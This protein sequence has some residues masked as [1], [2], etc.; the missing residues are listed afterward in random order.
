M[1]LSPNRGSET[2]LMMALLASAFVIAACGDTDSPVT[3]RV[4]IEG[5]LFAREPDRQLRL[6]ERLREISGLAVSPD[7]RVFAHDDETAAIYELDIER[8]GVVKVFALGDPALTGDFE[9][10]AITPAGEFWLM[11]ST[12]ELY[13]FR[14]GADGAH[15]TYER[16]NAGTEELCELEG[17]TYSASAN[18][19]ILA[20]KR[21]HD[22][23]M[24]G[25]PILLSWAPGGAEP[26]SEWRRAQ[27]SFAD[28]T[29]VRRFQ[30]S[31]VDIDSRTGRIIVLSANDAAMVELDADGG[32]LSAR[33]LEGP[34][35]Q[36]EGLVILPDGS[37]LISDE[38]GDGQ[39]LLSRYARLP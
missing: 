21:N 15:A 13:Q 5:S 36:A 25:T 18:S 8:G 23:A 28:A 19:L 17:L 12:G 24:R 37:L 38:G 31:S 26:A 4:E 11:T 6:P 35:P 22:R 9:G 7:G 32:L 14:E 2:M 30:P 10:L 27:E 34:H 1:L 3:R 39:A 33:E 16:F 20:C 29:A